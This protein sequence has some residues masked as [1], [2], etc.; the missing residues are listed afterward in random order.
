[1]QPGVQAAIARVDAA[2]GAARA[3]E[4]GSHEFELSVI[5]QQ[6]NTRLEGRYR[7]W[8]AQL[9][10][11]IRLPAKARLDREIGGHLRSAAGLRLDDAEHQAARRLLELWMNGLRQALAAD[12]ASAQ[13]A[14]LTRE[15]DALARRVALGDAARRDLDLFEA[16][17]AQLAA[18]AVGARAAAVAARQMLASEFPQLPLPAQA[19]PLPEPAAPPGEVADWRQRIVERSHEIEIANEEAARLA[20]IAARTR[21]DR[22][23]DPT[24]GVRLISDRGGAEKV[25]GLVLNIPIGTDYRSAMAVSESANAAAAEAEAAGVRRA[26][27]QA[28]WATAEAA[29]SRLVQW[30]AQ[31]Q[32]LVAQA[33]ASQRTR[34]AWELGEAPLAEYLL[35]ER[36]QRQARL[37][38]A[39]ARVDALQA[40]LQLRVDTHELWHAEASRAGA[41][42]GGTA[43]TR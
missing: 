24:V 33:A 20:L 1:A 28:A 30:Q 18:Q 19:P 9:S 16:E 12:E 4:V 37:A 23:P 14:L 35:A 13:Q 31:Q 2:A 39:L 17:R 43:P 42:D 8:E 3:R 7:E 6:R 27:E 36:S 25:V 21:A 41:R 10:R 29:Q 11:S 22:T 34:R 5:P 26:V 15:R 40:L 32:A 38:E